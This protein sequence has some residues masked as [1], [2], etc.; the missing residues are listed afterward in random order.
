MIKHFTSTIFVVYKNKIALH[1]HK[2]VEEWLPAGGHIDSNETPVDAGLREVKEEM[3]IEVQIFSKS[4]YSFDLVQNI[5][6]PEAILI[7]SVFDIK[8]GNHEHIDFVYFGIP[9]SH[10]ISLSDDWIWVTSNELISN[11]KFINQN[12]L[13]KSPPDD[14][15][16]LGVEAIKI[17]NNSI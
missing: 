4:N 17:V 2:K 11:K 13:L 15:I 14:V 1:W 7:E 12:G 9:L 16:K 5:P 3:G 8:V 10:E 6:V